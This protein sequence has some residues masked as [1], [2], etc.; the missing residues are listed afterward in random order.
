[1]RGADLSAL[2][3]GIFHIF[4][5]FSRDMIGCLLLGAAGGVTFSVADAIDKKY[6]K[7]LR[8]LGVEEKELAD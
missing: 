7:D 4:P 6:K 3:V 2:K 5:L 8:N 1:M